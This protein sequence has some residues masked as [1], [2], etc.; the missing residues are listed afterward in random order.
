MYILRHLLSFLSFQICLQVNQTGFIKISLK[1]QI[2]F[3][4]TYQK[5][6]RLDRCQNAR[7]WMVQIRSGELTTKVKLELMNHYK[8]EA[9]PSLWGCG[10]GV[11]A[12]LIQRTEKE[13][14]LVQLPWSD[15]SGWQWMVSFLSTPV[16]GLLL[17]FLTPWMAQ[18]SEWCFPLSSA[19]LFLTRSLCP[20]A[21]PWLHWCLLR[22]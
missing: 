15:T 13:S 3:P 4:T 19:F 14:R 16:I 2:T 8:S 7:K 1:T 10:V 20:G 17:L 9:S 18:N 5:L 12:L 21:Y 6:T 22:C 11:H